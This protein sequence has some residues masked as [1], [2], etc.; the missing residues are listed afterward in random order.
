MAQLVLPT[1]W[2]LFPVLC[3]LFLSAPRGQAGVGDWTTYSFTGDVGAI[4]FD[5]TTLWLAT[6]GAAVRYDSVADRFSVFTNTDGLAGNVL[7]SVV[8]DRNRDVWFGTLGKGLSRRRFNTGEWRTFSTLDGLAS[9]RVTSLWVDQNTLWVGTD[10]GL[11]VFVWDRD[12][13]EARDTFVFSDAYRASRGVPVGGVNDLALSPSAIWVGTETGVATAARNAPNLKD[14]ASWSLFN[15]SNGL[16]NVRVTA[17]VTDS[18]VVWAG[19]PSGVARYN[20]SSWTTLNTGLP[21]LEIRDLAF[22]NGQLWAATV[23]GTARFDG[24]TWVPFGGGTGSQGA[25]TI[26]ADDE[27]NAWIGAAR[28]GLGRLADG[29]WG[30]LDAGGPA[31]NDVDVLYLDDKKTL[32]V[33]FE[34]AGVSRL[35]SLTWTS[36]TTLDGLVTE[37]IT[38]IGAM[39]DGRKWFGSFGH[40]IARLDDQGSKVKSD[41]VWEQFNQNN[42]VFEGIP[43]DPNFVVV[44]TWARD[45]SGGQWFS[46]FAIGAQFLSGD[47][48]FSTFRPRVGELSSARI[49]DIAVGADSSVWFATDNRLSRYFPKQG[50]WSVYGTADGLGSSQINAV[51]VSVSG[52]VW[53]GDDAGFARIEPSGALSSFGLAP[54]LN[55]SRVTAI[56]TDARGNVW[57]GTP[58]GLGR[59]DPESFEWSVFTPDNSP[60]ADALVK[61]ILVNRATGEVWVGGGQGVSRFESGILPP[62]RVQ[63]AIIVYPNPVEA[64][65]GESEIVFSQLAD[66]AHV[67]I[68]T[69]DGLLVREIP[70]SQI[71]AQQVRWDLKNTSGQTVAGGVYLYV[72]TAPDGSHTA[73]KIAIIR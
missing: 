7:T 67:A 28:N 60:L 25:R 66:G 37:P 72:V 18:T 3:L 70:A 62:R 22:V 2:R 17:I 21:S 41:D 38:L 36:Y 54:G 73:G 33:G 16:P 24:V 31:S 14:P 35:D 40:G 11:S 50:L 61:T 65:R 55:T 12:A 58:A 10:D 39:P 47:G 15:R 57:V 51:A 71:A 20:G 9:Q 42:S 32:W 26:A 56:D 44:N 69:V 13:D 43:G 29:L 48:Q 34:N 63:A 4:A 6:S 68:V 30:F 49:R 46:N 27:G 23:N 1:A 8:V 59:F 45:L 19:T 5:Q 64:T 52:D 53:V